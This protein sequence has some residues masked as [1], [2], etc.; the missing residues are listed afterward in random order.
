MDTFSV[1]A[2]GQREAALELLDGRRPD[3]ER[4]PAGRLRV[5]L[6]DQYTEILRHDPGVRLALDPEDLHRMRIAVRRARAILRAVRAAVDAGWSERLGAELKWLGGVLGPRRDLDVLLARLREQIGALEEPERSAARPLVASLGAE[7]DRAQAHVAEALASDRYAKLLDAL[8]E[9]ARTLEAPRDLSLHRIA[10]REFKRLGKKMKALGADATDEELHRARILGKRARYAA[11]LAEADT[12]KKARRFI[13]KAK[14]FQDVL[15]S[16]Q[17]AIVAEA[18]LRELLDGSQGAGTGLAAGR[19][20]E[21]ERMRRGEA[22]RALPKAWAKL[23]RRG[24][25]AWS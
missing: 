8:E 10:A 22:R 11:E 18:R 16:H 7:R 14:A 6:G 3:S 9:G 4:G 15:G 20:V 25:R 2:G 19:L 23:E 24:R 12:G 21:R 1:E 5:L 17:D 13:A